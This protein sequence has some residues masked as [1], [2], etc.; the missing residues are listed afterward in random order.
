MGKMSNTQHK[1]NDPSP[2]H[3]ARL[4]LR[5]LIRLN[6]KLLARMDTPC[7]AGPSGVNLIREV[8]NAILM[9]GSRIPDT[10][11]GVYLSEALRLHGIN[12]QLEAP[13]ECDN[14]WIL[15]LVDNAA[16]IARL[17]EEAAL[18]AARVKRH[19]GE[20]EADGRREQAL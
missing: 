13:A 11:P 4:E 16:L 2:E 19:R 8:S 17:T 3:V 6:D 12:A 7:A 18:A 14:D 9:I 15:A 20:T 10:E 5:L 1:L